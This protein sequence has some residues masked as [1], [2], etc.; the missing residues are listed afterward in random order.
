MEVV[1]RMN[2]TRGGRQ[3]IRFRRSDMS[4][5]VKRSPELS[6]FARQR[7]VT[8]LSRRDE[9]FLGRTTIKFGIIRTIQN[10][11]QNCP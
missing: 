11:F 9:L 10:S 3:M 6:H 7:W 4:G 8:V 2:P 1:P 5:D